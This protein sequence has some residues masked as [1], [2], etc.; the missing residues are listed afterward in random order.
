MG[1]IKIDLLYQE[2]QW[3]VRECANSVRAGRAMGL[4][5][6]ELRAE[7]GRYA[8]RIDAAY[9]RLKQAEAQNAMP[10]GKNESAV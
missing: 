2:W 4:S 8:L 6:A 9:A 5:E 10:Y 7:E 1:P 3:L